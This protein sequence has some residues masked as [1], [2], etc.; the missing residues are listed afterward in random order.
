MIDYLVHRRWNH[1][2]FIQFLVHF[3]MAALLIG[4]IALHPFRGF[5]NC[6]CFVGGQSPFINF[7]VKIKLFTSA[8]KKQEPRPLRCTNHDGFG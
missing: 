8:V 7:Y 4:A 5:I 3:L 1:P 6:V 2:H